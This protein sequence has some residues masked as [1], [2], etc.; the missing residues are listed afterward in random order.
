MAGETVLVIDNRAEPR[1]CLI[2]TV[3]KPG[4]YTSLESDAFEAGLQLA[5]EQS[6]DLIVLTAQVVPPGEFKSLKKLGAS[7]QPIPVLLVVEPPAD[8]RVAD[9]Q[10]TDLRIADAW[11]AGVRDVLFEP[12]QVEQR[13]FGLQPGGLIIRLGLPVAERHGDDD[14]HVPLGIIGI[15]P[16]ADQ[17]AEPTGATVESITALQIDLGEE[18][19][20]RVFHQNP[21]AFDF[22]LGQPE[23]G[24]LFEGRA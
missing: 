1:Q 11:C 12:F 16:T 20:A 22:N 7:D 15:G 8:S 19:V 3:L 14:T 21:A 2:E 18:L 13:F 5:L 4:G 9:L 17:P 6:P 10:I 23:I 24:T